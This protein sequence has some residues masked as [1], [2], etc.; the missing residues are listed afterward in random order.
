MYANLQLRRPTIR[1][2]ELYVGPFVLELYYT[3]PRYVSGYDSTLLQL[4]PAFPPP[5]GGSR[6]SPRTKTYSKTRNSGFKV[7]N[8]KREGESEGCV[9]GWID[10]FTQHCSLEFLLEDALGLGNFS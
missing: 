3:G 1:V 6:T 2:R 9:G 8:C 7:S 5:G 10:I 4:R